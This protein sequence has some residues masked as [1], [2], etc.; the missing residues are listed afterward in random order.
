M[1]GNK[2]MTNLQD[3]IKELRLANAI[4]KELFEGIE[5]SEVKYH[6]LV[7]GKINTH[8]FRPLNFYFT[9]EENDYLLKLTKG[10]SI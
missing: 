5:N 7:K 3:K 10:V 4:I 9:Q 2:K 1:K 8:E 6:F